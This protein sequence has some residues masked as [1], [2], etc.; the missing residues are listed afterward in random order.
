MV[1]NAGA[2]GT[3]MTG[4]EARVDERTVKEEEKNHS[5]QPIF[6]CIALNYI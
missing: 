4:N 2:N 1:G 3:G 5:I 6:I